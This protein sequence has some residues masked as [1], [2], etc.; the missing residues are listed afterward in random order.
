MERSF[1]FFFG[2]GWGEEA[3]YYSIVLIFQHLFHQLL[4][5][6]HLRAFQVLNITDNAAMNNLV[7]MSF[8]FMEYAFGIDFWKWDFWIKGNIHLLYYQKLPNSSQQGNYFLFPLLLS[9]SMCFPIVFS[10]QFIVILN[11]P[12]WYVRNGSFWFY[13]AFLIYE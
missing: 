4:I 13:F 9:E 3:V 10:T 6:W 11:L 8:V 1:A 12:F 2:R 5:D 7:P